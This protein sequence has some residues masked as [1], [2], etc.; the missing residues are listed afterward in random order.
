SPEW[1]FRRGHTIGDSPSRDAVHFGY[2][3][4]IRG[5]AFLMPRPAKVWFHK[6]KK[7]WCT[8]LGGKLQ[9]LAKGRA[10]KEAALTPFD[11]LRDEVKLL[12]DGTYRSLTVAALVEMYLDFAA[13][14]RKARTYEMHQWG[15]QRFVD[16]HAGLKASSMTAYDVDRWS[17]SLAESGLSETS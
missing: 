5:R 16:E 17:T 2:T 13:K 7:F 14:K 8:K 4:R 11:R 6:H 9:Y 3:K 12:G 1:Q 10:N 15:L